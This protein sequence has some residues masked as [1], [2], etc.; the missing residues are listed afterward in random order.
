MGNKVLLI[1]F[2][3]LFIVFWY[4]FLGKVGKVIS[5][6]DEKEREEAKVSVNPTTTTLTPPVTSKP[7]EKPATKEVLY[8]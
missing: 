7:K 2:V 5:T 8:S 3:I 4:R 1:I 6:P